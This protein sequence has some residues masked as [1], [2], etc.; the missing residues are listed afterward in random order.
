MSL[1]A[2]IFGAFLIILQMELAVMAFEFQYDL[3]ELGFYRENWPAVKSQ[4]NIFLLFVF[5]LNCKF[6]NSKRLI[7]TQIVPKNNY[8]ILINSEDGSCYAYAV[9][10]FY[11]LEVR[12]RFKS[13][14]RLSTQELIDCSPD[15]DFSGGSAYSCMK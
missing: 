6:I 4:R 1:S 14:V 8:G 5:F 12:K 7:F 9:A 2:Q 13:I 15:C 10:S 11:E 3:R